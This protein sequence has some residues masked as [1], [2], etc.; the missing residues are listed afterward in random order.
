MGKALVVTVGF[1]EKYTIRAVLRH[2]LKEGDAIVLV[3]GPPTDKSRKAIQAVEEF[4]SKAYGP[5]ISVEKVEVD[6][7]SGFAQMV[8]NVH[9]KLLGIAARSGEVV[10]ALSGGMRAVVLATFVAA[11]LLSHAL[12]RVKVELETEDSS[13]L[14]EVPQALLNPQLLLPRL[15][16][17][18]R[19]ILS[20][21][22][23]GLTVRE[24]ASRLGKSESTI[25]RHL[26]WLEERGLV[27]P[28][29]AR[30]KRYAL[31]PAG[32]VI[33][34]ALRGHPA[35]KRESA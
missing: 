5:S 29:S 9:E 6:P 24:I 15:E 19:K 8:L 21:L 35:E 11:A 34:Q 17:G 25:R 22:T 7:A 3:T 27:A 13:A 26:A 30:P 1:D 14:L 12:T 28:T 16:G 33:L 18:K 10:L 32:R 23:D 20:I 2:G 4:L 31:T